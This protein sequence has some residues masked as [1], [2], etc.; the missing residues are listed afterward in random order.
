MSRK[1]VFIFVSTLIL[2][3]TVC[4]GKQQKICSPSSCG[5]I[6]NISYPFRL[7]DDPKQCGDTRYELNCEDN[8]AVLSLFSGKYRVLAINYNNFTIRLVDAGL[9]KDD[10][11]SLPH[12]FLS[13]S[14]FT[15][16]YDYG[17]SFYWSNQDP[18][19]ASQPE[20]RNERSILFQH[21]VYLNCSSPVTDDTEYV[22]TAACINWRSK[23]YIYAIPGD[24]LVGNLKDEC[25]VKFAATMT[26]NWSWVKDNKS[27]SYADIHRKLLHGF[28]L[29]WLFRACQDRCPNFGYSYFFGSCYLDSA[30]KDI[31]C[32]SASY[33]ESP[34]GPDKAGCGKKD[35]IS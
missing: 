35:L 11:S 13:Q 14:N 21:I 2:Q 20:S 8:V 17:E 22:E 1:L 3:Q 12:Y 5:T 32:T 6:S 18:F 31:K 34:L 10:C 9:Q 15:D 27:L 4:R 25:D 29:S 33:C 26:W 28:E 23:G 30:R 16:I 19:H 7:S 24:L